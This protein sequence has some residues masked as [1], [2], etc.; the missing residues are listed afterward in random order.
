MKNIYA[1]KRTRSAK[2]PVI[3]EGVMMANFIWNNAKSAKGI[4]APPKTLPAGVVYTSAP[5]LRNIKKVRGLP[6]T[7]PMSSPKH[8]E[9][10]MVTH[11][12][13]IKPI[14]MNDCNMV[15]IT[16]LAPTM[17]P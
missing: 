11:R 12:M 16:F 2:E 17:P 14:A 1:E 9:K 10:P 7:P 8:K 5:T 13:E 6:I 4:E 3:S 15:L